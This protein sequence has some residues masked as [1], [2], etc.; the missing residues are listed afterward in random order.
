VFSETV[1]VERGYLLPLCGRFPPSSRQLGEYR[2]RYVRTK[3]HHRAPR[4]IA[5]ARYCTSLGF[6]IR[7]IY[8]PGYPK[9]GFLP[10]ILKYLQGYSNSLTDPPP[11]QAR[12]YPPPPGATLCLAPIIRQSKRGLTPAILTCCCTTSSQNSSPSCVTGWTAVERLWLLRTLLLGGERFDL[13][14][15][16]GLWVAYTPVTGIWCLS[17]LRCACV[18]STCIGF[19]V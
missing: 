9:R 3:S 7:E 2:F 8:L 12:W 1:G 14:P 11:D 5:H 18:C 16:Y 4:T 17:G 6:D 15:S 19:L 10:Q 13:N